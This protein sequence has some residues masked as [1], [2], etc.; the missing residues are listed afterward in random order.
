MSIEVDS[1]KAI[2]EEKVEKLRN[3]RIRRIL[4]MTTDITNNYDGRDTL[5]DWLWTNSWDSWKKKE[6]LKDW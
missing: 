5:R 3:G 6:R 2:G 4:F 1:R